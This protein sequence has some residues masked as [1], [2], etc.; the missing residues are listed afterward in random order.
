VEKNIPETGSQYPYLTLSAAKVN[1]NVKNT[2]FCL[3]I[4]LLFNLP[5]SI[6]CI[7]Q[8]QIQSTVRT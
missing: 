2:G 1:E 4:A 5:Q 7:I 6:L 3:H 8:L